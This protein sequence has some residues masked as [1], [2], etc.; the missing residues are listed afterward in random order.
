MGVAVP[1]VVAGGDVGEGG[2]VGGVGLGIGAGAGEV[3]VFRVTLT[4]LLVAVFA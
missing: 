3:D 2:G 4:A 1:L